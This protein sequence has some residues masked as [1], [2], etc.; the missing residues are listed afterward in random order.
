METESLGTIW[1]CVDCYGAHHGLEQHGTPDRE[2]LSLIPEDVD[3]TA[4]LLYEEHEEDCLFHTLGHDAP[5]DYECDC[6]RIEFS[7]SPCEGCGSRLAGEREAL[8]L[9][10]K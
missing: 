8:T 7:K 2:P 3:V 4:G 1:V 6:E 10:K 5:D 9:W